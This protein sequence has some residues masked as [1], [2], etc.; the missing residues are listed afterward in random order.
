MPAAVDYRFYYLDN[1]QQVLDWIAQRYADLLSEEERDFIATFPGL[2]LVS[3][4][5]FVRMMMRRGEF[6]RTS[7]LDYPEIGDPLA[8]A[9]ALPAPWLGEDPVLTLEQLFALAT[10][11]ELVRCF[12][13]GAAL[14]PAR[15]SELL[16][17]LRQDPAHARARPWSQW[18]ADD[19]DVLLHLRQQALCD[20]L[21]LM[22]FGNLRQDWS[23][24]VLAD[25]GMFRYERI[26]FAPQA[27]GFRSR[28][29]IDHY[30]HL[31]ACKQRYHAGDA[32][33]AILPDLL[34]EVPAGGY[35]N[36]WLASRFDRLMFQLG[37]AFEKLQDWAQAQA[38]YA[39]SRYPGARARTVRVLEKQG[40]FGAAHALLQAALRAPE[41]EA[42]R[43]QLLRVAPRLA[44]QLGHPPP[45]REAAPV[46][47]RMD[48]VLPATGQRVE[49]VVQA[50]LQCA[51]APVFYVE[52]ALATA[53]FGL[54]CWDAIFAALPGA[55]FHPFQRGPA[56]L[57]SADFH[58]RRQQEFAR[59]LARLDDGSH[60]QA[61]LATYD[62][63]LGLQSSFVAWDW[64]HREMLV[65]ALECI[66]AAHLKLWCLRI[67]EDVRENRSG[68]PD[69][70]QFWPDERRYRMIEVKGPGDRLQDNQQRWLA[71]CARH[72]MPVSVCYLQWAPEA[73]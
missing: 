18:L 11:P 69:L 51:Q 5:L 20:R 42:E 24:F 37:Q 57:Y 30:L 38:V 73:A 34:A 68:F 10:K 21:R 67:L 70:I 64:L 61:I 41:N 48:L 46:V 32:P 6:F 27:R 72:D 58:A 13:L 25:L 63:K 60:H 9:R 66:P 2:P 62:A 19:T 29:D 50:H 59:C 31:H 45:A 8:A 23:E 53:L 44:R 65:M 12:A 47:Q 4:A 1:F 15:K 33:A 39:A 28:A 16:E 52:N 7:K 71:Y 40:R 49:L 14:K 54:L 36:A 22:F 17:V 56:D 43:Q 3:R 26:A 55:F 35:D